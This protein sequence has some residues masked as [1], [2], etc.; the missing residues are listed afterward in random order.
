MEL[1]I[2]RKLLVTATNLIVY[3]LRIEGALENTPD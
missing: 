3:E 1:V 2:V